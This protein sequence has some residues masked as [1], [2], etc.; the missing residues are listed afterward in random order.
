[1]NE[2]L[3]NEND[4][5]KSNPI[6]EKSVVQDQDQLDGPILD[7]L[8]PIDPVLLDITN[9]GITDTRHEILRSMARQDLQD[10]TNKMANQMNKGR[11]RI[12]EFQDWRSSKSCYS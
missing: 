3:N 7:N 4:K 12:K 2:Q 5:S 8:M 10:Y 1:M 9:H 11:K 6:S